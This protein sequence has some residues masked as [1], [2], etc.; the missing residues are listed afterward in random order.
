MGNCKSKSN[1]T[2]K[3][4]KDIENIDK[5]EKENDISIFKKKEEKLVEY[6]LLIDSYIFNPLTNKEKKYDK[7]TN[8]YKNKIHELYNII[9]LEEENN[10]NVFTYEKYLQNIYMIEYMKKNKF[11]K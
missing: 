2:N 3:S 7:R 10:K 8:E 6:G 5:V 11:K 1:I 4:I 9:F